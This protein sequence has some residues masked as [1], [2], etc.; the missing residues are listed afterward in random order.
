MPPDRYVHG[1]RPSLCLGGSP[2]L[3]VVVVGLHA[4]AR[5]TLEPVAGERH[6]GLRDD[7][8][9]KKDG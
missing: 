2:G 3:S 1:Y 5:H 9:R 8:E 7:C 6:L 4:A